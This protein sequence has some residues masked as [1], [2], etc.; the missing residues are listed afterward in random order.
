MISEMKCS[1]CIMTAMLL[2]MFDESIR[3]IAL[4]IHN[5]ILTERVKRLRLK[6]FMSKVNDPEVFADNS[7]LLIRQTRLF[8]YDPSQKYKSSG[9]HNH[10]YLFLNDKSCSK[11]MEYSWIFHDRTTIS[12]RNPRT[13]QS[14]LVQSFLTFKER[15]SLRLQIPNWWW[16]VRGFLIYG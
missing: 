14:R 2:D 8:L 5:T 11:W 7:Q 6:A 10:A 16:S 3:A 12:S 13:A 9:E 1:L 15:L 4:F